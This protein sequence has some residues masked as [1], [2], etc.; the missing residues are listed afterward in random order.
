MTLISGNKTH[1]YD[2]ANIRVN[3][4]RNPGSL[5][6]KITEFIE[7]YNNEQRVI[8]LEKTSVGEYSFDKVANEFQELKKFV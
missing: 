3:K 8:K 6:K 4:G 7:I 1:I 5:R 2:Y